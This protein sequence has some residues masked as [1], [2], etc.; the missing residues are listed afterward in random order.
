MGALLLLERRLV[1]EHT[2]FQIP[3][4][5]GGAITVGA[6]VQD[7]CVSWIEKMDTV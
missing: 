4:D 1:P 6:R 5:R 2:R 3:G 7:G